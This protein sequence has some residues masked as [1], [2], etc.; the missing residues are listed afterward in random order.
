MW[1]YTRQGF[2][3]VVEHFKKPDTLVV[4][5]R[6]REDIK[7]FNLFCKRVAR[8]KK[9]KRYKR[10]P[11]ADYRYRVEI[12]REDFMTVMTMLIWDLTYHNFKGEVHG[13]RDRDNAYMECWS[14][15]YGLQLRVEGAVDWPDYIQLEEQDAATTHLQTGNIQDSGGK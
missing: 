5:A 15:M 4:R 7:R 8:L 3:S 6:L 14:A 2:Y 11:K 1:L 10:T 12:S 13:N 9:V